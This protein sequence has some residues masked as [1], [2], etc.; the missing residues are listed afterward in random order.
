MLIFISVVFYI[1]SFLVGCIGVNK[2]A[3]YA[4]E[5]PNYVNSYVGG[6]AYNYIINGTYS[7]SFFVIA[8]ALAIMATMFLCAY[9]FTKK[10]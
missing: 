8:S 4:N 10:E 9:L 7:T 6:D 3:V 2:I 1:A 5:Y